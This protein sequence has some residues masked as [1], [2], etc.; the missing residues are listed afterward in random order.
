[1]DFTVEVERSL[2]V[3]DG[4]IAV[5]D[6]VS[7][8]EPQSET[9]WRQADRYRVPRI[10]FINKLDRVG[11]DFQGSVLSISEKLT[12][13]PVPL[14]I[15][16]GSESEFR[17][18]VDVV[19][20]RAYLW[21]EGGS[22]EDF[23]VVEI[24]SDLREEADVARSKVL[25]AVAE[26]DDEVMLKYLEG[27]ELKGD[28][29][30]RAIRAG[31]LSL[32][33]TPVLCGSAFKNKCIQPLLDAVL[34]Y[35][36]SP[37]DVTDAF[38]FDPKNED[39]EIACPARFDEPATLLAFKMVSDSFAG[40]LA[41]VR[42]YSGIVKVG[43]QLLN[44]RQNK[45]ERVQ[46]LVKIH[47]N[48]REEVK[49]LR[50]GDI[51]AIIGLRFTGTG[52]TLCESRR[53]VVLESIQFPEPVISVAIEAKSTADQEKM[54]QALER[55]QQEDP[56]CFVRTD[57]ETGQ[58]LLSGM[59]EL[60][61]EI[62]VDRMF[63][64]YK[65]KANVGAPQ[66]S[67]RETLRAKASGAATFEKEVAGKLQYASCRVEVFPLER[68]GGVSFLNR[69]LGGDVPKEYIGA[70][71]GGVRES[72]EVGPFGLPMIDI[73]VD[74][75]SVEQR[76]EESSEMAFK[77]AASMAF[78]DAMSRAKS[79]LLEPIFKIE[80]VTPEDYMG[81][82]VGDLNSRRGQVND[83]SQ[84][85]QYRVVNGEVPLVNLFSYA[86]DL[87]SISQGRATFSMEFLEYS[88][89]PLKVRKEVLT[90]LG[91]ES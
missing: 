65:V 41:F 69:V 68:G 1:M 67:Y 6:G 76:E 7:G 28:E 26:F 38:G 91:R 61:L 23:K 14:Q 20:Q 34:F 79:E 22:G 74:L 24:P 21:E 83:M 62:L 81:N 57:T 63:R 30:R 25:E 45:K 87:R 16:V 18:V 58:M 47:A 46:R 72:A 82:I 53:P 13:T 56:S 4:A 80:V 70:I 8:V 77:V 33:I 17:G 10:C 66:V 73:Q 59:G 3:L 29:V 40:S 37:L 55:L 39:K 54:H 5:F 44:P 19:E 31:T 89:V 32:S 15:P 35:L 27:E 84:R 49:E 36:P 86:T 71:E 85:G 2:R 78:R 64:E 9:V 52:D 42:V 75:L 11:S 51:G 88:L 43:G 48:S 50:A 12:G 90:K 60:H